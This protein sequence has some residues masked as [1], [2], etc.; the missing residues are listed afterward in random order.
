MLTDKSV[1]DKDDVFVANI[2][3]FLHISSK[4]LN[5]C[6]LICI[7][8]TIASITKSQSFAFSRSIVFSSLL[9]I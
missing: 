1:I 9:N 6:F 3:S 8:S 7:F 5:N 2:V 4:S